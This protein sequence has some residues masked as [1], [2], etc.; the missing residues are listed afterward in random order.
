FLTAIFAPVITSNYPYWFREQDGRLAF[1][2]FVA[3]F[4]TETAID[5]AFNI[6][7]VIF[8]PWTAFSVW[9]NL[10]ARNLGIPGR[11]RLGLVMAVFFSA[12]ALAAPLFLVAR[13]DNKY[14]SRDFKKDQK[15]GRG[16]GTYTVMPYGP[17]ELDLDILYK[18]PLFKKTADSARYRDGA[19]HWMGTDDSG[20]DVLT[21]LIYGTRIS[22]TIGIVAVSI[23]L[24][25]GVFIGAIAGYFG[26][27]VDMII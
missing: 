3:L 25:I 17:Q 11:R 9:Y 23:Y 27:T 13:P 18:P 7:L 1:P 22:I 10:R 14:F 2:W 16:S 19:I 20:R 21:R 24:S 6:A 15:E 8:L 4:N 26:G 5:Y 12:L